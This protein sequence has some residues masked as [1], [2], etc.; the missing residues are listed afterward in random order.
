MAFSRDGTRLASGSG[1]GTLRAWDLRQCPSSSM[2]TGI[3]STVA[4]PEDGTR[5]ASGGV[6]NTIRCGI[7]GIPT[8][9]PSS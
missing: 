2:G 6:D 3:L 4:L 7:W 8:P 5:L 1:D 9:R